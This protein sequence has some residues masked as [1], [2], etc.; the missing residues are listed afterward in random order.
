M[1]PLASYPFNSRI[2][3][4]SYPSYVI[5]C[6]VRI[7]A[8]FWTKSYCSIELCETFN[9][10]YSEVFWV[11]TGARNRISPKASFFVKKRMKSGISDRFYFLA[12]HKPSLVPTPF[13]A[14]PLF[15]RPFSAKGSGGLHHTNWSTFCGLLPSARRSRS[16]RAQAALVQTIIT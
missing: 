11:A 5:A 14:G 16:P 7:S 13:S 3:Y 6:I 15:F 9:S 10:W 1:R 4:L 2:A 12:A 8:K